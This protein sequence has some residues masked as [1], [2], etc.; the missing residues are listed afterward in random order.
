MAMLQILDPHLRPVSP[1]PNE[2]TSQQ[3]YKEH[4]NLAQE[5][6]KVNHLVIRITPLHA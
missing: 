3:V 4:M 5:Y 1:V 6:F 2:M